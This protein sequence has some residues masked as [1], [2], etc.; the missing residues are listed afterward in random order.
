MNSSPRK[1]AARAA[2]I[3]PGIL[4][5]LN[6][7]TTSSVNLVEWMA[8]N[9]RA[10]LSKTLS[11]RKRSHYAANILADINQL[12]KQGP[13]SVDETIGTGLLTEMLL[14]NDDAFLEELCTHPADLVR[15]WSAY[16]IGKD[17][18]LSLKQLFEKI[19]PLAADPHF[20]VRETAWIG[21]RHVI[22]Q[23]LEACI[24]LLANW[25]KSPDANLRRFVSEST[26]PRGVWCKH[27]TALKDEPELGLPLLEPL[28]SDASKYV[29][30][31]VGNWLN[32]ASKTRKDFVVFTCRRWE[33]ESPT[34]ETAY[35]INRALRTLKRS[36]T[37]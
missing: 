21:I 36:G 23:Q 15:S 4:K 17:D 34:K 32:D 5:Q 30:D 14:N 28:K 37:F 12:K 33:K 22:D 9:R 29:R 3:P 1:G 20:I 25:T 35:I 10:L 16:A 31:S 7:G 27:I 8:I 24:P 26:R 11:N 19:K 18:R 6:E 2:D 13:N